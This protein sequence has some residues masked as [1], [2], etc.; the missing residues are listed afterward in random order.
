MTEAQMPFGG[1]KA[2]GYGGFG[3]KAVITEFTDLRWA[4]GPRRPDDCAPSRQS[5]PPR[6]Q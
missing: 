4:R 2:S 1:V 6:S 3:S 5:R